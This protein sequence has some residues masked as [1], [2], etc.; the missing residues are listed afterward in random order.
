MTDGAVT[1]RIAGRAIELGAAAWNRCANPLGRPDPHPFTRYEFF[2]ALE[3]SRS[4]VPRTGWKPIHIVIERD[5]CAEGL[6]PL[7]VKSHSQGEYVF[8]HA[9]ADALERAGGTYYPKLQACVPFTPVTGQRLLVAADADVATTRTALL[10]AG[11]AAVEELG[12]SSLH[13]TFPTEEEW[14][15]AQALGYLLRT[16]C[17]FHWENRGYKSFD[18]FLGELSSSKR[19]NLRKSAP[20]CARPASNSIGSPAA[21]SPRSI[22]TPSSASTWTPVGGNGVGPI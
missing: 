11:A 20:R 7:Y 16:D 2:E 6:M 21:I 3:V 19:K 13:M 9:W 22:G 4:A 12:C 5:G 14:Q 10:G 15:A 18:E 17:Q 1:A 8:D